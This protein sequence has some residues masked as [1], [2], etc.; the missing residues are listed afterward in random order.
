[1]DVSFVSKQT[2][3]IITDV[4]TF[5]KQFFILR[6]SEDHHYRV[7]KNT[8][9]VYWICGIKPKI[10]HQFKDGCITDGDS[11]TIGP[12]K[13]T[14]KFNENQ[15]HIYDTSPY[16]YDEIKQ[17][18]IKNGYDVIEHQIP[19]KDYFV[20]V[21]ETY[22]NYKNEIQNYKTFQGH[23]GPFECT[24]CPMEQQPTNI[25]DC[26]VGDILCFECHKK[27][28]GNVCKACLNCQSCA[29]F[30]WGCGKGGCHDIPCRCYK[31]DYKV[32]HGYRIHPGS[33]DYDNPD[34][35][36]YQ[37]MRMCDDY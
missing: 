31:P 37:Y 18:I 33:F 27:I 30:C 9:F 34:D 11:K 17:H 7:A 22:T 8:V 35:D 4:I 28:M 5:L 6:I 15:L 36:H 1:M 24:L 3:E 32:C 26:N 29:N 21:S 23:V 14:N 12:V 25:D 19:K 13:I 10:I 16:C 2:G 20:V